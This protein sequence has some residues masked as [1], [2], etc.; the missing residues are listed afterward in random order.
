MPRTDHDLVAVLEDFCRVSGRDEA[1]DI[2]FTRN[3]GG[4]AGNAAHISH[5]RRGFFH[6]GEDL[7]RGGDGEKDVALFHLFHIFRM[8]DDAYRPVNPIAGFSEAGGGADQS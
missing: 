3:D 2:E 8:V 4:V 5:D 1:G 6:G 7:W